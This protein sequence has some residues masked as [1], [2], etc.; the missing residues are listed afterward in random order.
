MPFDALVAATRQSTNF[1]DL[2]AHQDLHRLPGTCSRH[3]SR[4]SCEKF[5]PSFWYRHQAALSMALVVASPAVGALAGAIQGFTAHSSALTIGSSFAWMCLVAV[6]TGTGLIRLRAGSHWRERWIAAGLLGDL[7]VPD[8][9]CRPGPHVARDL[10]GATTDPGR[11]DAEK[12]CS[13]PTCC[14]STGDERVCLGIWEDGQVFACAD[15]PAK[16]SKGSVGPHSPGS[17]STVLFRIP[18]GLA[19]EFAQ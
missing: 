5:G 10:P 1:R 6:V 7:G 9:D 12:S 4:L 16:N 2:D 17:T 19:D 8:P 15:D 14:S 11:T 3:T 18:V 13:I